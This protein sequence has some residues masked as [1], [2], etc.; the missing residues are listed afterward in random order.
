MS[1]GLV[2]SGGAAYGVANVGVVECLEK[3]GLSPDVI[4]GSSMGA[5]VAG[6]YALGIETKTIREIGKQL[7]PLHDRL[8]EKTPAERWP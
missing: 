5:V 6:L 8:M 2:L 1:W 7:T 3:E 4:A